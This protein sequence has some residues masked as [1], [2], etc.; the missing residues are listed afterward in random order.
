M[1]P[2][3]L[4]YGIPLNTEPGQEKKKGGMFHFSASNTF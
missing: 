2:I 1:G 4:D 3:K